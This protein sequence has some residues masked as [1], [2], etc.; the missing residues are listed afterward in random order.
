[1]WL[2]VYREGPLSESELSQLLPNKRDAVARCL[3]RLTAEGRVQD[4]AG[5]YSARSVV[6]S[7][8]AS[9]GWEA[10][11]LDHFQSVVKTLC[12][13]LRA[14]SEDEPSPHVGGS[15]YTMRVWPGHPHENEVR[16]ALAAFRRTHTDLRQRVQ[17]YNESHALPE[18]YEEVVIYGGECLVEKERRDEEEPHGPP[19]FKNP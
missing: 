3:A 12:A 11:M 5:R 9:K 14:M 10:G 16:G 6:M 1:V 2:L 8:S 19:D 4:S 18:H 7:P 13:R 17:A 15:T